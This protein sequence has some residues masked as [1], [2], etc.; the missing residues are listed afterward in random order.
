MANIGNREELM[1][2]M[3]G[4]KAEASAAIREYNEANA[5]ESLADLRKA[6]QKMTKAISE[7][8]STAQMLCFDELASAENPMLEAV[9]KLE[10]LTI[11]YK[12]EVE[13][14]DE[15]KIVRRELVEEKGKRIDLVKLDKWVKDR[16][17]SNIGVNP[18]WKYMV[19]RLNMM[20][21]L[22][23]AVELGK[24]K[25]FLE[26]M[27][28]CYAIKEAAKK[29]DFKNAANPSVGKPISATQLKKAI[30]EVVAAMVGEEYA[31]LV[32]NHDVKYIKQTSA[33]PTKAA[34]V[35]QCSNHKTMHR[36]IADVCHR[37]VVGGEY[38]V[39][40]KKLKK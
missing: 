18:A 22:N 38:E 36:A 33:K 26:E 19:E 24:T 8:T 28:D 35:V 34:C 23:C 6:E 37:V 27:G 11:G 29:I 14:D 4:Y 13:G 2:K 9:K 12:D 15:A 7:Y 10:F 30:A 21:S 40:Y 17:G 32:M 1:V 31:A 3:A 5:N 25:E 20:F 39:N 16:N